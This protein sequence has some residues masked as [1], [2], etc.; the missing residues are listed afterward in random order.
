MKNACEVESLYGATN[1]R[2]NMAFGETNCS[3]T[4][5]GCV[6]GVCYSFRDATSTVQRDQVPRP[7]AGKS[8]MLFVTFA[9]RSS[10]IGSSTNS[11][12]RRG[13]C[14]HLTCTK[15]RCGSVNMGT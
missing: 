5:R 3:V 8:S 9:R 14:A 11:K 6:P 4:L 13:R 10:Q 2:I 7:A 1:G 12:Q 15:Q